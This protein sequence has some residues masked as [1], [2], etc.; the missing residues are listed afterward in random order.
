MEKIFSNA[1]MFQGSSS[2]G[3][4]LLSTPNFWLFTC[5]WVL[6]G[7]CGCGRK[8]ILQYVLSYEK[9]KKFDSFFSVWAVMNKDPRLYNGKGLRQDLKLTHKLKSN[10]IWNDWFHVQKAGILRAKKSLQL[11]LSP[12]IWLCDPE[13]VS[14][15]FPFQLDGW[16]KKQWLILPL[17]HHCS[18]LE[19]CSTFS[20][21]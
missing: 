14:K 10:V 2:S 7:L 4:T 21:I 1:V 15:Q 9:L 18:K 11:I 19:Q 13:S 16:M 6:F 5:L 20:K 3:L 17:S 12:H 8:R